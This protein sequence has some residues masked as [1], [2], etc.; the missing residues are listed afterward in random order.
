MGILNWMKGKKPNGKKGKITTSNSIK[1]EP[2]HKTHSEE[3]TSWPRVLLA[4]GTFGDD[5]LNQAHTK[6]FQENPSSPLQ[7][8]LQD[9]TPEEIRKLH[10]EIN[11]LLDEHL[12]QMDP[13]LAF[14]VSKHCSSNI[15]PTRQL[16]F[17]SDITKNE[18]Y[19][20][21]L[22]D[23]SESFKHVILSKGKDMGMEANDTTLIGKRTLSLLLKKI[24][25]CG[26]GIAPAAV[27]PPL[28]TR[29]LELKIEKM[30][31][32]IL[33]KKIYPQSFNVQTSSMKKYLRKKNKRKD[34]SEDE[35]D[36]KTGDGIKWVQTDSEYI[37]LEI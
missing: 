21:E 20:D 35:K 22:I 7:Q 19:S 2:V 25:V 37:V 28:R 5:N 9:L 15:F 11:L 3:F 32:T 24:F 13:S 26:G 27:A 23:E 36:D 14:E 34:K 4:I 33:H 30:L 16:S 12:K 6:R 10:K 31:R 18:P 29:T 17:E 8:H 1:D